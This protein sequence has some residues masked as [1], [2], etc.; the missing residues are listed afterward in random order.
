MPLGSMLSMELLGGLL[1]PLDNRLLV[2][3]K[4]GEGIHILPV[5]KWNH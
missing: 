5:E 1:F 4:R 2:S 3:L